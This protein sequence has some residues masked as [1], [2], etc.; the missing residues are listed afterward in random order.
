MSEQKSSTRYVPLRVRFRPTTEHTQSEQEHTASSNGII[1]NGYTPESTLRVTRPLM[2]DPSASE[3]QRRAQQ[4]KELVRLGNLLRA[5]LGID[6]VFQQMA[7]SIV[8]CTG[9]HMLAITLFDEQGYLTPVAFAGISEEQKRILRQGR[10]SVEKFIK[11]MRPEFRISQSYFISHEHADAYADVTYVP[12]KIENNYES[13]G[14]HPYDMLLVPL[15][16]PREQKLLGFLSLDDPEDGKVPT[17]ESIEVAELF[18]NQVAIAIDN[19]RLFQ[20]REAERAALE[21]GILHLKEDL[22]Q[23]QRGDLRVRA[24]STHPSLQPVVDAVN[25][26]AM[27]VGAIL[28]NMQM[29]SQAV[30]EHVR[31][32]RHNSELLVR[33]TSQQEQQVHQ[34]SHVIGEI[35]SMMHSVSESAALLSKTAIE[36]VDVTI[37]A[38]G[39]VDRSVEGMG[40]LREATMQS[41]RTMKALSESGQEI[42][43]TILAITDLGMR[44][45]L[46]ALNAAI[47]ATRAGEHGQGFAVIAQEIRTLAV[48][49]ADAARK[50]G[51]YIRTIQHETTAVS[52]S[53]E[54][55][56]QQ[57]VMQTELVT[58]T[59]VALEAISIVTEQLTSLIQGICTTAENQTQGSQLV[60]S[61]VNEILR[62]TVAINQHMREMQQSMSHLVELSNSLRSRLSIFRLA[63]R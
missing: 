53:V 34:I 9:F 45:H 49:S 21:Q 15:F 38:Q 32:V 19:T 12:G 23:L 48:Q 52:Q 60:V 20:E 29:V 46:L 42:N 41:A 6:E 58:Q 62:M 61:A 17:E 10:D 39:A 4:V 55:S 11:L 14:W 5:D 59:G 24:R 36:A 3:A 30:D 54:L 33:D 25:E 35:A 57:V 47:E 63:E 1:L 50:V 13:G 43:E 22:E 16:S 26:M 37:E 51:A 8:A 40:T 28:G 27:Q 44:M 31:N 7:D 18:A 56:T 2:L